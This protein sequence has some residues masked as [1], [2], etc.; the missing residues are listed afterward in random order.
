[1]TKETKWRGAYRGGEIEI[2]ASTRDE[3]DEQLN[4]IEPANNSSGLSNSQALDAP[5]LSGGLGCTDAI[6]EALGTPWGTAEP[7]TM[8]ELDQVFK[9]NAL[10]FSGGSLS[11]S[12]TYLTKNGTIRRIDKGGKWGY[13]SVI[14]K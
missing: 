6:R 3:L 2:E 1:M 12:L 5:T 7:R 13:L 9:N 10:Y 4:A 11:G 14:K 8:A